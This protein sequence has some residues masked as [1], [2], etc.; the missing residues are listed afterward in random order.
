MN[1]LVDRL[2]L[3]PRH[4]PI[5][6]PNLQTVLTAKFGVGCAQRTNFIKYLPYQCEQKTWQNN[7]SLLNYKKPYSDNIVLFKVIYF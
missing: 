6:T 7:C 2:G 3:V 5:K 1:I 4:Q